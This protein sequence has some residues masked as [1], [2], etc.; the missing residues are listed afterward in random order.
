VAVV[1]FVVLCLADWVLVQDL[2]FLGGVGTDPNSMIPFA[3]LAV[4]GYLALTR[5]P[6]RAGV[7]VGDEVPA[8]ETEPAREVVPA[9]AVPGGVGA[10]GDGWRGWLV[11]N[12]RLVATAGIRSL[13]AVGA[14][15]VIV[16]GAVPMAVAQA[17]PNADPL[18]ARSVAHSSAPRDHAAP[19]FALIDQYGRGVTAA[20]L[21]GRLVL[22][23]F[24]PDGCV[25]VAREFRAAIGLLGPTGATPTSVIV[26]PNG[27]TAPALRAFQQVEE[28]YWAAG[29]L[30]VSGPVT[31]TGAV[32]V[33]D[34]A[35]Y[36]RQAY[37]NADGP[38]TA[39]VESSF[40]VLFADAA[41]HML[42]G[43]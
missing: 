34:P 30:A 13:M 12:R 14:A 21:R 38:D 8:G 33:I 28:A 19:G 5:L 25:Q 32:Y 17:S 2:G 16:L 26:G 27:R 11:G 20:G 4:G 37:G 18:L 1:A 36:I 7:P 42:T 43:G 41:R 15:G 29:G 9:G 22:L 23:G 39:A 35:G 6:A 10:A 31:R 40:A 3:L 24:C